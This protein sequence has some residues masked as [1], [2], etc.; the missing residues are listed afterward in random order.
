MCQPTGPG[1][2]ETTNLVDGAEMFG[3]LCLPSSL[4]VQNGHQLCPSQLLL[5]HPLPVLWGS[6]DKARE[7]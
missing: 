4:P 6:D 2:N 1:G 3:S 7:G 5:G